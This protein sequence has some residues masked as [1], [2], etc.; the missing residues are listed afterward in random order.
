MRSVF[1]FLLILTVSTLGAPLQSPKVLQVVGQVTV[2][3]KTQPAHPIEIGASF[4]P[5]HWLETGPHSRV[6]LIFQDDTLVRLGQNTSFRF[7]QRELEIR[8]GSMLVQ[9]GLEAEKVRIHSTPVAAMLQAT[10]VLFDYWPQ[11]SAKVLAL[12]GFPQLTLQ[13]TGQELRLAPGK[14]IFLKPS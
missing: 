2:S 3:S 6:E 8:H 7:H 11:R 5:Q 9:L 13:K 14:M 12:E 4:L 1:T 10:T